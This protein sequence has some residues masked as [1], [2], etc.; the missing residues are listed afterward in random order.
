LTRFGSV[1][2]DGR[3]DRLQ[4]DLP[5]RGREA[6]D[7]NTVHELSHIA[8][9]AVTLNLRERIPLKRKPEFLGVRSGNLAAIPRSFPQRRYGDL[10][11]ADSIEQILAELSSSN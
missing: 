7:L 8:G 9:P 5:M 6:R 3:S 1:R 4:A 10:K 11:R 2:I